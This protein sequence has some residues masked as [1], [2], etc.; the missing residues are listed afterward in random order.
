MGLKHVTAEEHESAEEGCA[1]Y[2]LTIVLIKLYSKNDKLAT[3]CLL[4]VRRP[5]PGKAYYWNISCFSPT[6]IHMWNSFL[7]NSSKKAN[8]P[9]QVIHGRFKIDLSNSRCRASPLS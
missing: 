3:N 4:P 6:K 2:H 9:P 1:I 7:L 8:C 5:V